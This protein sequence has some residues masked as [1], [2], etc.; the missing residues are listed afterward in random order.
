ML[1]NVAKTD[2]TVAS[3]PTVVM[4]TQ[5]YILVSVRQALTEMDIAVKV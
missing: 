5:D 1:V 3:T 4:T 2:M